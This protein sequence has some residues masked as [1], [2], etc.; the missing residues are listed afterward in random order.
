MVDQ[1]FPVMAVAPGGSVYQTMLELLQRLRDQ[2]AAELL[3]ISDRE[4]ALQLA[5]SPISLPSEIPEWLT[6]LVSI[7]QAQLFS[8]YLALTKGY[9]TEKPRSIHKVTRTE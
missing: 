7:V 2:H 6:P 8:Y 1:G 9:N 5:Q 3:V 4:E